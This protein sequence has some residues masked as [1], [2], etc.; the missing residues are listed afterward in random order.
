VSSDGTVW[1]A[2]VRVFTLVE[3]HVGRALQRRHG[4]GLSEFRALQHLAGAPKR[5]LRMQ[6]LADRL[7]LNQSSV[8]RLV[9]R[10]EASGLTVRHLCPDDKRGV[11]TSMTEAGGDRLREAAPDYERFL[12]EALD[13]ARDGDEAHVRD[14]VDRLR[15][16][17]AARLSLP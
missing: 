8:S 2:V 4:I 1:P 5:E 15:T 11:Y 12:R 6:E 9:G 7:G 14:V 10:L 3:N 13:R 16:P 17:V